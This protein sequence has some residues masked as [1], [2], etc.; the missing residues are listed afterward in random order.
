ML[1]NAAV[2]WASKLLK[3]VAHSNAEA[4]TAPA[5]FAAKRLVF[6]QSLLHDMQL[7]I[8]AGATLLD[9]NTAAKDLAERMGVSKRT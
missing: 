7:R 5:C 9:D 4:E 8:P 2:D 3:V 1:Y 6:V